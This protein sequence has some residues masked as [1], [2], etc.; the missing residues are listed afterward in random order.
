MTFLLNVHVN[1]SGPPGEGF[2]HEEFLAAAGQAGELISAQLFADPSISAV[3]R[4]RGGV[5]TAAEGPYRPAPDP[6][7]LRAWLITVASRRLVDHVRSEQ[8][9]RRVRRSPCR[10]VRPCRGRNR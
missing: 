8:A 3:V 10:P 9:R 7:H 5:V 1:G 4:L 6:D 2:G